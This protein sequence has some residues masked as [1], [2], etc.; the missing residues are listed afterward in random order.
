[1]EE[2]LQTLLT[3]LV[4]QNSVSPTLADG[5]GEQAI[6][7]QIFSKCQSWGV[8]AEL[9][10]V[11]IG[12]ANVIAT[13]KG[14]GKAS[15]LLFNAHMDTVGVDGMDDP[16]TLHRDADRL[17]GRG[18]YDMKGSVAVML[19]L[20]EYFEVH[21]PPCQLLFTF[22]ADEEDRS[23]G[24]E[25][26]VKEWL[27]TLQEQ[28]AGAFVLEPTEEDIGVAH[29]GF[30][31]FE[32][33]AEGRAAHGSRPDQGIDAILP[34][35]RA[36]CELEAIAQ[37]LAAGHHDKL[38]GAGSRHVSTINGGTTWSVY[39]ADAC[40][41]WERRTLPGESHDLLHGELDRVLQAAGAASGGAQVSGDIV[42]NRK[43]HQVARESL[44]VQLIKG[45]VP[46]ARIVGVAYW[47]DSALLGSHLPTVL[48]GPKGHGA[49]AAD[50]WVSLSSLVRVY[51]YLK[52][53]IEGYGSGNLWASRW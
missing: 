4:S 34:L 7:Q 24:T 20:A 14:R 45:V 53:A 15:P 6:A 18:A 36:L 11:D 32:I 48:F 22:V 28:P 31:W 44:P 51:E 39:P 42:Y 17:Y 23:I 27:P 49:H 25:Y 50:E 41:R 26:L 33:Q 9:Q 8:P 37:E 5:P 12:R 43:P 29:K 30:A 1:M 21:Q 13:V 10:L 40:L 2:R 16:F 35:G 47:A 3:D 19:A 52:Q 46:E 38:L